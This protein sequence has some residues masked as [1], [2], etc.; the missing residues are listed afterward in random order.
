M[1]TT[2]LCA[3]ICLLCCHCQG[4]SLAGAGVTPSSALMTVRSSAL[5]LL[6]AQLPL[7]TD[8]WVTGSALAGTLIGQARAQPWVLRRL[9]VCMQQPVAK[10]TADVVS[11]RCVRPL[12]R[13]SVKVDLASNTCASMALHV[14]TTPCFKGRAIHMHKVPQGLCENR[15]FCTGL[16]LES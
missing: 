4:C 11:A 6:C 2:F 15:R 1:S 16:D 9:H 7:S 13:C 12:G 3:R 14:L 5:R 10:T 8:L